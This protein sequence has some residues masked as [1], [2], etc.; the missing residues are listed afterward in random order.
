MSL[1]NFSPTKDSGLRFCAE[2]LKAPMEVN[3]HRKVQLTVTPKNM[4]PL[5]GDTKS[6]YKFQPNMI[7]SFGTILASTSD[8]AADTTDADD[9]RQSD[10]YMSPSYAGDTKT[11]LRTMFSMPIEDKNTC[12]NIIMILYKMCLNVNTQTLAF[13]WPNLN[14]VL[15]VVYIVFIVRGQGQKSN[16]M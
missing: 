4:N 2:T 9:D 16:L 10:P 12:I 1:P 8:A 14:F 11:V 6:H 5:L 13:Q 3:I 15:Y 7:C